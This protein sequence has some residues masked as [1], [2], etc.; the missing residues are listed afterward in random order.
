MA[1][2]AKLG[3]AP[4]GGWFTALHPTSSSR[5]GIPDILNTLSAVALL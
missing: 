4:G 5:G 2:W 3:V 1:A